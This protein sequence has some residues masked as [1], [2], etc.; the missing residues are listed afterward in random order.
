MHDGNRKR[1]SSKWQEHDVWY[2][3]DRMQDS[4]WRQPRH[5]IEQVVTSCKE[6]VKPI[7]GRDQ[8]L[9]VAQEKMRAIA[10]G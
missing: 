1:P 2:V 7:E 9:A 4:Y 8:L 5:V 3:I 6:H 10:G